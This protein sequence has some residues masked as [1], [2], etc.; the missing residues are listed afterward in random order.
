M[1]LGTPQ[2]MLGAADRTATATAPTVSPESASTAGQQR[3]SA[4]QEELRLLQQLYEERLR[5]LSARVRETQHAIAGDDLLGAMRRDPSS[6]AHVQARLA[7]ILEA[8][9]S[10]SLIHI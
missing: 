4:D 9:L 7:E 3:T 6:A 2:R 1:Q 10:L 5:S 8:A